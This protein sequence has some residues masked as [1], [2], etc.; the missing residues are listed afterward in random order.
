MTRRVTR[1][2]A[3]EGPGWIVH[4]APK[5]IVPARVPHHSEEVA[6]SESHSLL[7]ICG[8]GEKRVHNSH[9]LRLRKRTRDGR[10]RQGLRQAPRG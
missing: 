5:L 1:D 8:A 9:A 4:I 6:S 2:R 3:I 10:R 7:P